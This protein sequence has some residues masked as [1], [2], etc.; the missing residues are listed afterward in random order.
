MPFDVA[1][2]AQDAIDKSQQH[3]AIRGHQQ[4]GNQFGI[5]APAIQQIRLGRPPTSAGIA[6][7]SG[8]DQ[9]DYSIDIGLG[10]RAEEKGGIGSHPPMIIREPIQP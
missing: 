9:R 5:C 1:A 4:L 7:I 2:C 8:L 6:T 3:R 10:G